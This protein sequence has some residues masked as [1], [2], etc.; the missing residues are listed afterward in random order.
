MTKPSAPL[1]HRKPAPTQVGTAGPAVRGARTLA[2]IARLART[3]KST[4]SRVL[5]GNPRISTTTR[6]RV[7]AIVHQHNYRPNVLARALSNGHTGI[8]GVL[9]SNISSGFF[10]EVIRG[11]NIAAGL[12]RG[13]LLVSFAHGNEDYFRLF[14]ELRGGG[15]VD[16]L[17]L[18]DPPI[19]LFARPLPEQ[20]LPLVLCASRAPAKAAS[21]HRVDSV[22]VNNATAMTRLVRH[23][24]AQGLRHLVHLAG[25][26]NIFDAQQRRAAFERAARK[27]RVPCAEVIEN[28]LIQSD[29]QAIVD[30]FRAAKRRWPDAFVAFNDSVAFGVTKELGTRAK[31]IAITGWDNSPASEVLDITSVEMPLTR[32]GKMSARLLLDRAASP[33]AA[34]KPARRVVLATE[35]CIRGSSQVIA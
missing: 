12:Y 34:G 35:P 25:P 7:L 16:G 23:L 1:T 18:I 22:T 4:V 27:L 33:T 20:H 14:D 30:R 3:T 8:I 31:R 24:A 11:I 6:E 29:G 26:Q 19:E 9:A 15:Q 5:A 28:Q 32:L 13:H 10:A 17:V 2:D 21:W